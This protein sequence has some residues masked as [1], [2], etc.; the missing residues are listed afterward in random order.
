VLAA[1]TAAQA[2]FSTIAFAVPVLAPA[3]RDEY[4]L[5]L[6]EIGVVVAAEWIGLTFALLPWGFAADRFGERWTLAAGLTGCAVC[7]AGAAFA[8]DYA[9]LVLLLVLCGIF[10]GSVQSGS[11][12]AVMGWFGRDERGLALGVRQTAVPVGGVIAALV[13]PALGSPRAGFLF[14]SALVLVGAIVGALVLRSGAEHALDA[15]DVES[16]LHNWRLWLVCGASGFYLVSQVALM[17]FVVLFLHDARGFSTGAAAAVL[18]VAQVLAAGLRIGVGHW[19]DVLGSRIRPLRV[20]GVVVAGMLAAVAVAATADAWIL[21]PAIAVATALSMAWN[22]LS[23]TIAAELG[24]RRSGAAIGFQQTV[25]SAVGVVVPVAFAAAVSASSWQSAFGV[26]ALF[27]LAGWW[28]LR[29]LRDEGEVSLAP[30][31]PP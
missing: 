13:L 20:I 31:I 3:L 26:A 29:P 1:G 10:G 30:T 19:S 9:S 22:G 25:L 17:S 12:R 8:P 24:G 5:S 18:A 15:A 2:S 28:M 23:F 16:T 21:L 14:L 7:L 27:P 11:G 6:T 4:D